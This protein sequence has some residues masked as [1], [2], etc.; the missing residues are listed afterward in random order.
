M[1]VDM[2]AVPAAGDEVGPSQLSEVLGC[3]GLPKADHR[4]DVTDAGFLP[5]EQR[6]DV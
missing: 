4:L 3:R 1:I 6:E 2:R 5:S